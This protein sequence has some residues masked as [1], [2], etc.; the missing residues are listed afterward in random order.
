M[1]KPSFESLSPEQK[2]KKIIAN[3]KKQKKAFNKYQKDGDKE[4]FDLAELEI[5]K[6]LESWGIKVEY[7]D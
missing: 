7:E 2:L 3:T 4:A 5:A 6:E 1:E